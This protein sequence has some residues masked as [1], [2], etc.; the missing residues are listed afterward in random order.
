MS[1]SS[2]MTADEYYTNDTEE[3][4]PKGEACES[5]G[6]IVSPVFMYPDGICRKWKTGLMRCDLCERQICE[7]CGNMGYG[8]VDNDVPVLFLCKLR[9]KCKS[10][11]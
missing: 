9:K 11:T 8:G 2:R 6:V 5:C 3:N 7:S 4:K 10:K 1:E